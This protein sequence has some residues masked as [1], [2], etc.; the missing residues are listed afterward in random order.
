MAVSIALIL[1]VGALGV[2]VLVVLTVIALDVRRGVGIG[3]EA[4]RALRILVAETLGKRW[5]RA[6][7]VGALVGDVDGLGHAG[8]LTSQQRRAQVRPPSDDI[9]PLSPI[10]PGV[11]RR[12]R[13]EHPTDP[14][15]YHGPMPALGEDE[16]DEPTWK[17][18]SG[19][20]KRE[21]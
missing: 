7:D 8:R 20:W 9:T 12:L 3:A 19:T 6:E 11:L 18:R 10:D 2:G 14:L 16:D 15:A 5:A 1:M 13:E 21:G 4:S 17:R